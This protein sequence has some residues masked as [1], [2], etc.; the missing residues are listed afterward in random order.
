MQNF[1]RNLKYLYISAAFH[2]LIIWLPP[3][4]ALYT[5]LWLYTIQA[6]CI[7]IREDCH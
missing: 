2:H 3:D 6:K 4:P 7:S 5:L 1:K